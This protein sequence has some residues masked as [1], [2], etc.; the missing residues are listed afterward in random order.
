MI[1]DKI[2][3]DY[4]ISISGVGIV[5]NYNEVVRSPVHGYIRFIYH[6][7]HDFEGRKDALLNKGLC[8][9]SANDTIIRLMNVNPVVFVG[10]TVSPGDI[11]GFSQQSYND[12]LNI[13][14][15]IFLTVYRY[16]QPVNE[17]ELQMFW[18]KKQGHESEQPVIQKPQE[19]VAEFE[20]SQQVLN[21]L[22][23][24]QQPVNDTALP[25]PP[26]LKRIQLTAA[27]T[28]DRLQFGAYIEAQIK[29]RIDNG[30]SQDRQDAI[31]QALNFAFN[32]AKGW[33]F[34]V[35]EQ[36]KKV[37]LPQQKKQNG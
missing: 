4:L 31:F 28:G 26:P 20:V 2:I 33:P 25:I 10:K 17:N 11:I 12:T 16:G 34:G 18:I 14:N 5:S 27:F 8:I 22:T 21:E 37:Y 29:W 24:P 35:N 3:T 1:T 7:Y 36:L 30:L 6:C 19:P 15:H 13:P 9:V 23:Q 32:N